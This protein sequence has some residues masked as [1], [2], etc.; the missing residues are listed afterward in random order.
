MPALRG[1]GD[2]GLASGSGCSVEEAYKC[3]AMLL[4]RGWNVEPKLSTLIPQLTLLPER[5]LLCKVIA[6]EFA[7]THAG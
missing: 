2:R 3:A 1:W 6:Y 5:G 7:Q 4:C